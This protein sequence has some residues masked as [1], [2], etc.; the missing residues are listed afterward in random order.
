M[1]HVDGWAPGRGGLLRW[2]R[3][4]VEEAACLGVVLVQLALVWAF[5]RFPSQ[6][7]ATHVASAIAFRDLHEPGSRYGEVFERRIEP[8]P[9]WTSHL[10]LALLT[11]AVEPASAEKLLVTLALLA[12]PLAVGLFAR[13]P[14]EDAALVAATAAA[15]SFNRALWL[16]FDN[17]VLGVAMALLAAGHIERRR[18][19]E[20]WR[21]VA[22]VAILFLALYFTHLGAWAL[23]A[24]VT[25]A[26]AL[27]SSDRIR[28]LTLRLVGL[29]PSLVLATLF[30]A[31]SGLFGSR[32]LQRAARGLLGSTATPAVPGGGGVLTTL[33]LEWFRFQAGP[34]A[35]VLTVAALSVLAGLVASTLAAPRRALPEPGLRWTLLAL[36]GAAALGLAFGPADL[37]ARGGFFTTRLALVMPGLV[38]AGACLPAS[39]PLR[40]GLLVAVLALGAFNLAAVGSRLD[41]ANRDLSEF[42]AALDV[43][44]RG[45]TLHLV[46]PPEP[47]APVDFI[48]ANLYCLGNGNVFVGNYEA[49]TDHFPLRY[50]P[51]VRILVRQLAQGTAPWWTDAV[52]TWDAPEAADPGG[53]ENYV[54]TFRHGR[55]RVFAR[56]AGASEAAREREDD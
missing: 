27:T 18:E 21:D 9:N 15:F 6:D 11:R 45:R 53:G 42:T 48:N 12:W 36:A 34:W 29:G 43:V 5:P 33:A 50:R 24:V 54:E 19:R 20:R 41:R 30:L 14:R 28:R 37:G 44:G 22:V 1:G 46:R 7:R 17:F 35:I 32:E 49:G 3:L 25:L 51:G 40:R 16:G 8:I 31:R 13:R 26:L 10:A 2:P 4:S 55:L 47:G 56:R 23:G 38:L 52:L 39:G